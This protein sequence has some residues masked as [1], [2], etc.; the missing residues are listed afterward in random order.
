MGQASK[1]KNIPVVPS[2]TRRHPPPLS[3]LHLNEGNF[4]AG[5]KSRL[6]SADYLQFVVY[7]CQLINENSGKNDYDECTARLQ[8]RLK[9]A[10]FVLFA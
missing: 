4:D 8:S 7:L 3:H 5:L 10:L 1:L 9:V 2:L 6:A